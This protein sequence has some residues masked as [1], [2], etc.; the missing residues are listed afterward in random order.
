MFTTILS[1]NSV[2]SPLDSPNPATQTAYKQNAFS[3]I[4]TFFTIFFS[5]FFMDL[6]TPCGNQDLG[7]SDL[8][9]SIVALFYAQPNDKFIGLI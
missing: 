5:I 8:K 2:G 4:A 9:N 6:Y 1:E 3:F 7:R